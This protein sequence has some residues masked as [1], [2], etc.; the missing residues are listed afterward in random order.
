MGMKMGRVAVVLVI[1]AGVV[2]RLSA[3]THQNAVIDLWAQGKPAFGD[4]TFE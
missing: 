3:Q 2:T 1:A 4:A